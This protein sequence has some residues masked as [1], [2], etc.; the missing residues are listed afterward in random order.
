MTS[1]HYMNSA[2][3]LTHNY[4]P[5]PCRAPPLVVPQGGGA[6][7]G[8]P[9]I[10]RCGSLCCC[11][12]DCVVGHCHLYP[13]YSLQDILL[14]FAEMELDRTTMFPP[15]TNVTFIRST[16]E[17]FW[18]RSLD[19]RSTV[20]HIAASLLTVMARPTCTTVHLFGASQMCVY[21][22]GA[23]PQGGGGGGASLGNRPPGGGGGP[24]SLGWGTTRGG[25]TGRL[26]NTIGIIFGSSVGQG[27]S[28]QRTSDQPPGVCRTH[29]IPIT[30]HHDFWW[31]TAVSSPL[32]LPP[33]PCISYALV[34]ATVG[35]GTVLIWDLISI[36]YQTWCSHI[37]HGFGDGFAS[38]IES[39]TDLF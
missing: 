12:G 34:Q 31:C 1:V 5:P 37:R 39:W 21:G 28:G 26:Q 8:Q 11:V 6:S 27:T 23:V 2:G 33:P 9:K 25:G 24:S 7:L 4:P 35:V 22:G 18:R 16:G 32:V 29:S 17:L 36:R 19:I 13:L 20:M 14:T 10:F 15:G 38:C 3:T 30:Y